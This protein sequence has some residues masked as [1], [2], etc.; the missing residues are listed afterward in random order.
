VQNLYLV[1]RTGDPGHGFGGGTY[2]DIFEQG[3]KGRLGFV[4]HRRDDE[5]DYWAE[6]YVEPRARGR[7]VAVAAEKLLADKLG[8]PRMWAYIAEGNKVSEK[9]HKRG[10]YNRVGT[11][12]LRRFRRRSRPQARGI[13]AMKI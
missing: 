3:K 7:G 5:G 4:G 2:W 8:A 6:V 1:K 13:K 12:Y 9:A 10:G 11:I